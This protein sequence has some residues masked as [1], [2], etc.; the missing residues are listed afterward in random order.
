MEALSSTNDTLGEKSQG[1]VNDSGPESAE[2]EVRSAD[3][4]GASVLKSSDDAAAAAPQK[5][6]ETEGANEPLV[7]PM[8]L[9]MVFFSLHVLRL[10]QNSDLFD[11]FG[12]ILELLCDGV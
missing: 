8:T 3:L 4:A 2:Q 1:G 5:S 10:Y 7:S 11:V 9:G 12:W 6:M